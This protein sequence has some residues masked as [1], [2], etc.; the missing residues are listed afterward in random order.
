MN[1]ELLRNL[2]ACITLLAA[3][4]IPLAPDRVEPGLA[5]APVE[6]V[7]AVARTDCKEIREQVK[8]WKRAVSILVA[9]RAKAEADLLNCE[10]KQRDAETSAGEC[11][12]MHAQ[13]ESRTEQFEKARRETDRVLSLLNVHRCE[14]NIQSEN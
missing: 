4:A 9:Y 8:G 12:L 11:R 5:T 1:N 14:E 13:V 6:A 3:I 10:R 7:P 2:L